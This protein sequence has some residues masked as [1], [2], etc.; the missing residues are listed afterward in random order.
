MSGSVS[1]DAHGLPSPT[2]QPN[3]VERQK[4]SYAESAAELL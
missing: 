1:L 4:S 3:A 2:D